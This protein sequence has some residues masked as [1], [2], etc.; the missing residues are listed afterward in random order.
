MVTAWRPGT[1]WRLGCA[2]SRWGHGGA[3]H[4]WRLWHREPGHSFSGVCRTP[5]GVAG[6]VSPPDA[7]S[8]SP[9][10][11]RDAQSNVFGRLQMSLSEVTLLPGRSVSQLNERTVTVT[12]P[13]FLT[14]LPVI[15]STAPRPAVPLGPAKMLPPG[16]SAR[17]DG[18]IHIR[19]LLPLAHPLGPLPSFTFASVG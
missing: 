18:P 10:P 1:V 14:Y 16:T 15:S 13:G 5:S 12:S 3:P 11:S 9:P 19:A 6:S 4:A 8:T 2:Q 7:G 17:P